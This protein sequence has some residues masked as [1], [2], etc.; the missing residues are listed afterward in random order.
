MGKWATTNLNPGSANRPV[1]VNMDSISTGLWVT[2]AMLLFVVIGVR[3]AFVAALAGASAVFA[4]IAVPQMPKLGYDKRFAAGVVA[5][6]AL[7][8]L[9]MT[10]GWLGAHTTVKHDDVWIRRVL[11]VTLTVIIV[12]LLWP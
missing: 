10:G 3:V 2:G 4:R 5:G 7:A 11:F 9:M 12:K 1:V 6:P 8:I